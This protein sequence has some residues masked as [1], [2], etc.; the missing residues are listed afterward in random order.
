MVSG[1]RTWFLNHHSNTGAYI[2]AYTRIYQY[3]TFENIC[4]TTGFEHDTSCIYTEVSALLG[5]VTLRRLVL[6]I[7]RGPNRT[8][9]AFRVTWIP[10][11]LTRNSWSW[12]Q[13]ACRPA[14]QGSSSF[15]AAQTGGGA[16]Q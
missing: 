3:K 12:L 11:A 7:R 15:E 8:Q 1:F 14:G 2:L 9:R 16:C 10:R 13:V 6:E 5:S 4:I